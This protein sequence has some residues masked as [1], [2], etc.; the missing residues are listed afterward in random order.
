VSSLARNYKIA[1][2][3]FFTKLARGTAITQIVWL[4]HDDFVYLEDALYVR[5]GRIPLSSADV[6]RAFSLLSDE[7]PCTF[8]LVAESDKAYCT[9]LMDTFGTDDEETFD[10]EQN[11]FYST[12]PYIETSMKFVGGA[13]E[14]LWTKQ[15]RG[16]LGQRLSSLDY[17]FGRR[18]CQINS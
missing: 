11:V 15:I 17:A 18:Q 6:E 9:L 7:D 14:W 2:S 4:P 1:E 13:F 10:S 12:D 16:Y 3:R 8:A 5:T